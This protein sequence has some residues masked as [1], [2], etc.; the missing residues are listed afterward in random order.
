MCKYKCG[1]CGIEFDDCGTRIESRGE[2]FGMPSYEEYDC[3]PFC[4]SENFDENVECSQCGAVFTRN[5]Y[6]NITTDIGDDE[7]ALCTECQVKLQKKFTKFLEGLSP[8]EKD[9]SLEN[10]E[11]FGS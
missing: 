10:I 5:D 6:D 1:D 7:L 2:C 9:Y 8:V 4:Q 3:C 11:D